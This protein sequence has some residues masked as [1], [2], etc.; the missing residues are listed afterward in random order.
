MA[1]PEIKYKFMY[2]EKDP[3]NKNKSLEAL[4]EDARSG[5]VMVCNTP[6][7]VEEE[8]RQHKKNGWELRA[9]KNVKDWGYFLYMD[10]L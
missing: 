1:K 10:K 9:K 8:L 4:M 6:K 5:D 3:L 7:E 2:L